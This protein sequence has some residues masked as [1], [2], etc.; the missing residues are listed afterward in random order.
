MKKKNSDN[1]AELRSLRHRLIG[2][3]ILLLIAVFFWHKSQN[4]PAQD[5]RI[6]TAI[7]VPPQP[8]TED[9]LS[10]IEPITPPVIHDDPVVEAEAATKATTH[11]DTTAENESAP[12]TATLA[13][14][15]E[16]P[17]TTIEAIIEAAAETEEAGVAIIDVDAESSA[18]DRNF[19]VQIVALR[20]KNNAVSLTRA[21]QQNGFDAYIEQ[22]T[23]SGDI[24]FF[25][26]QIGGF[27][28][29]A[30]AKQTQQALLDLDAARYGEAIII[31]LR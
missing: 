6:Q 24:T 4:F 15:V 1:P 20:N 7:H 22:H 3:C 11:A 18:A 13:A 27:D 2:A 10:E 31:D 14:T 23:G 28:T 30:Q 19:I 21:L 25:R 12:T 9:F 29:R 26:V 17:E 16:E 5:I 8:I